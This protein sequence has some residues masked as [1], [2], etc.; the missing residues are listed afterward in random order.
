MT[1]YKPLG[2]PYC[3]LG[4][5]IRYT[6][7]DTAKWILGGRNKPPTQQELDD[8]VEALGG[9]GQ[10][11]DEKQVAQATGLS[12]ATLQSDRCRSAKPAEAA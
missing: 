5:S 7:T 12:V 1:N 4:R 10:L 3:S 6:A 8:L 9:A 11:L 2:L